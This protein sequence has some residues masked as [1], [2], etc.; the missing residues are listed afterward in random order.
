MKKLGL[1]LL[2]LMSLVV[3]GCSI[4][5]IEAGKQNKES[6]PDCVV[7]NDLNSAYSLTI[8]ANREEIDNKEEFAKLLI[9]RVRNNDF[10]TIMFSYDVKGYPVGLQMSVYLSEKAWQDRK[11][12]PYMNISFEQ[13]SIVNGYNIVDDYDKFELKI[14]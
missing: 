2:V 13:E 6:V 1:L 4:K 10:K 3:S 8:I 7:S 11:K 5:N 9:E 14:D 12:E